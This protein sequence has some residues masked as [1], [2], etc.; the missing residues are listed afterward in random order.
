MT[1]SSPTLR[2]VTAAA[3]LLPAAALGTNGYFSHGY[4][5]DAK[6]MAGAGSALPQT[7]L[8]VATNPAG[9][10]RLD[11]RWDLGAAL[12]SPQRSYTAN[13]DAPPPPA[14]SIEPGTVESGNEW[15]LIPHLGVNWELDPASRV[16]LVIYG[17]GGLNTEYD[18][19]TWSRFAA[20]AGSPA[21]P[22][23]EFTATAPT[24]VDLAQVFVGVPYARRLGPDHAVGVMPIL[25][26][27][28]FKAE[29]LE[30]FRQFSASPESVTNNGREVVTGLGLRIGWLGR[31]ADRVNVGVSLQSRIY[32][33]EFDE[34][35]GLFAEQGDFDVPP[36]FVV[37]LAVDVSP[38]VTV[39]ADWERILYGEVAAIANPNNT[40]AT[41]TIPSPPLLGDDDGLGFGWRDV[42]V[43]KLGVQWRYD[44]DWTFRAGYSRADEPFDNA[45]ALFNVLAPATVTEH[46]SVGL[47]RRLGPQGTL[48]AAYTRALENTIPGSNPLLTGTQTGSVSMDQH[49]LEI[50]YGHRF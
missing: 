37:G 14:P 23:G 42:D 46:V 15:F 36:S 11:R 8:T 5:T 33:D 26:A 47:S 22:T 38:E 31:F 17:N 35:S 48:S 3:A 16:G 30:P 28:S 50:S 12:F 2:A 39:V 29:G 40:L 9:L 7:T 41:G 44:A 24:G 19:A 49:D 25:A 13:P 10:V 21:N 45:Q 27:Q 4:G 20:P 34:Y 6:G 32:M 1:R 18:T 43:L